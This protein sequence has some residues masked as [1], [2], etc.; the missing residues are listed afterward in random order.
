MVGVGG[1]HPSGLG[2]ALA[3]PR[4]NARTAR[5]LETRTPMIARLESGAE[6]S[7]CY[8][9]IN[10]PFRVEPKSFEAPLLWPQSAQEGVAMREKPRPP[11]QVFAYDDTL[12]A[13]EGRELESLLA[14][15]PASAPVASKVRALSLARGI[16]GFASQ[17]V[18]RFGGCRGCRHSCAARGREGGADQARAPRVSPRD[19]VIT[20][21]QDTWGRIPAVAVRLA[22]RFHRDIHR[23][24][25]R[26]ARRCPPH[27]P[28][29]SR[30]A[31]R[32]RVPPILTK[33]IAA[34]RRPRR[35]P[36]AGDDRMGRDAIDARR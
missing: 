33:P 16:V 14:Y 23:R 26:R 9:F 24:S 11:V 31:P 6:S 13:D 2:T 15:F 7:R 12:G 4:K 19:A 30:H 10:V 32:R 5:V 21:V 17:F 20:W 35:A 27:P 28:R 22:G 25:R 3:H 18:H 1:A 8:P 36:L 29:R 34:R